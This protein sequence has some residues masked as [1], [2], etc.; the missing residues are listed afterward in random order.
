MKKTLVFLFIAIIA[1]S[2]KPEQ[3]KI[4]SD[5]ELANLKGNVWKIDKT[6]HETDY[7][8]ACAMKAESNRSKYVYDREGKLLESCTIDENGIVNESLKCVYNRLGVCK[9]IDKYSGDK[10]TGKEIP[11]L[12]GGKATGCKIFDENGIIETTLLYVYSG[13]DITEEKTIDSD[14]KIVGSVQNEFINGQLVSQTEKDSNGE[15]K[16]IN[17]IKRNTGNDMIEYL[18]KVTTDNNEFKFTF[19]YE[20]DTAGNWIKQT[21]FYD[22]QIVN[23]VIRNIEYYK[24]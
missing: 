13:D 22:G 12:Q 14:G 7:K 5:L 4:K 9:E 24:I 18:I 8:C 19:E 11:V 6:I 20:Y 15:V 2:C 17:K 21:K 1:F 23:I 3:S 16:T 10:L